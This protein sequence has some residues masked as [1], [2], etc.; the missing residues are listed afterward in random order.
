MTFTN[1][2]R[3]VSN[4]SIFEMI[5]PQRYDPYMQEIS[6]YDENLFSDLYLSGNLAWKKKD[7]FLGE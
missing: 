5:S 1:L 2:Q 7:S 3:K 6:N 4:N